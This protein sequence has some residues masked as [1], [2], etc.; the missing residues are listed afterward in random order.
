MNIAVLT[1]FYEFDP[2]YSLCQVVDEQLR[3]IPGKKVLIL[4]QAFPQSG[5]VWH[6]DDVEIRRIP[7]VP[8]SN[9]IKR[10]PTWDDDIEKLRVGIEKA[11]EG[12]DVV[13]TED[14][15]FQP[16]Q[17][18]AHCAAVI[19]ANA[20]PNIKWLHRIHSATSS[21]A[22]QHKNYVKGTFPNYRIIFPNAYDIPRI[23]ACYEVAESQIRCVPHATD[24]VQ[25]LMTHPL[26]KKLAADIDL[27]EADVIGCL[28]ARLDSGKQVEIGI[29]IFGALKRMGKS[30]RYLIFDFHSTGGEKLVVR[31]RLINE[32]IKQ[33]LVVGKEVVFVS[34][35]SKE[36]NLR[37]PHE[38]IRDFM[39]IGDVLILPSRSETYSL[40]TQEA[41]L[42]K[43]LLMLNFD[44][45]PI[46]AVYG[47]DALYGKFSSNIDALNGMDGETNT[48]YADRDA[49]MMEMAKKI[50]GQLEGSMA[51]RQFRFRR[52]HR[53]PQ[54]I[55]REYLEPL[56]YE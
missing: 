5:T 32:C 50:V 47:E 14:M 8:R 55:W 13:I 41:A 48:K 17:I 21:F 24:P 56:L 25:F 40:V 34:Q 30:V 19:V 4:D 53:N 15:I 12:I 42:C 44:F 29:E 36:T 10:D 22:R 45:V 33:G 23:A 46:R 39:V 7:G 1:D 49:Y 26:S 27:L 43:N 37:C 54:A 16:A 2:A 9:E 31:D 3:M 20:H 28:P 35:W 18:K 11:I 6:R 52:K 38:M 51:L